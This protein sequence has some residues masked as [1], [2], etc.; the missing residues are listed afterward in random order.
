MKTVPQKRKEQLDAWLEKHGRTCLTECKGPN[1]S[2]LEF[3][4]LRGIG[5]IVQ[6]HANDYGFEVY[7]QPSMSNS[8]DQFFADC[9]A[10]IEGVYSRAR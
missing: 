3:L 2:R 8:L 6:H 7:L 10:A 4:S 5:C 1:G 9:D